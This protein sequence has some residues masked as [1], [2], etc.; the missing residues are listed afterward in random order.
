ML[1]LDQARL[2][3]IPLSLSPPFRLMAVFRGYQLAASWATQN[4][5]PARAFPRVLP[6]SAKGS[7]FRSI[8]AVS[9]RRPVGEGKRIGRP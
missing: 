5:S 4:V 6:E 2:L 1:R 9:W 8:L 7:G 3:E